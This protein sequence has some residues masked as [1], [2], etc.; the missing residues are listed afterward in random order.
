MDN[1]LHFQTEA[2]LM[3]D[4]VHTFVTTLREYNTRSPLEL[5]GL[6]CSKHR[7]WKQGLNILQFMDQVI[8]ISSNCA[9][10]FNFIHL[11]NASESG[12]ENRRRTHRSHH[13]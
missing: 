13:L 12:A 9:F 10:Y 7:Q 5:D 4:A 8:I 11:T 1:D 6:S 2:A 3:T